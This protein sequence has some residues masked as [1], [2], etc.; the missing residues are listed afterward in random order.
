MQQLN[1]AINEGFKLSWK[2]A[3]L[4]GAIGSAIGYNAVKDMVKKDPSSGLVAIVVF[5]IFPALGVTGG[6]LGGFACGAL[7]GGIDWAIN[8]PFDPHSLNDASIL[9]GSSVVS[10]VAEFVFNRYNDD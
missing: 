8:G 9:I 4:G 2:G 6:T 5:V 1:Y 7:K 10:A 3:L